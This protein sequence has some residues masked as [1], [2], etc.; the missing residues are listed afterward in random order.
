MKPRVLIVDIETAPILAYSWGIWDQNIGL[1]QIQQ[2]WYILS[3]AAKW[4]D[5][6]DVQQM[7]QRKAKHIDDDKQILRRLWTLLDLADIVITQ[8]GKSFDVKKI[9][10][11]FIANGMKPTSSFKQIDTKLLAKKHFGFTSNSLE[12]MSDKLCTKYKKLKHKKFPGM[13][14][15]TECL[16]GNKKAWKCMAEYNIHDVLATEELYKKLIPWDNSV[17]FSVY[18]DNPVCTCGSTDFYKNGFFYG[19]TGRYQRY[20]CKKCGSEFRDNKLEK[21]TSRVGTKR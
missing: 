6:K 5:S 4:L 7:D 3:W 18:G 11:R 20:S 21:T 19:S 10:A 12:Y 16:K 2:D 14:L 15:W 13:E 9:N 8:N 17:S 1:N